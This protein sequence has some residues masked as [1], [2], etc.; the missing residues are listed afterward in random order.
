MWGSHPQ[1]RPKRDRRG[2]APGADPTGKGAALSTLIAAGSRWGPASRPA[3]AAPLP[4]LLLPPP[5]PPPPLPALGPPGA[6]EV[7]YCLC[8]RPGGCGKEGMQGGRGLWGPFLSL[9]AATQEPQVT[10]TPVP[11]KR[12]MWVVEG[13]EAQAQDLHGHRHGPPAQDSADQPTLPSTETWALPWATC[14]C[15]GWLAAA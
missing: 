6:G 4:P 3:R 7:G 8:W 1:E 10:G 9:E 14:R 13:H 5:T 15:C 2:E 12:Q 11:G